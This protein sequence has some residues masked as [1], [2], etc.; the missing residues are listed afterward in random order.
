MRDVDAARRAPAAARAARRHAAASRP[1][2]R[3]STPTLAPTLVVTTDAAP[4]AAQSTPGRGGRQGAH[5][6]AAATGAGVDLAATLEVLAGLGVL[7]AMVEGGA[8]RH[9]ALVEAGLVDRLVAY[10]GARRV[11]GPDGRPA[12]DR[13][14]S[15]P[16]RR[17]APAGAWSTSP[18]S[19]PT[20]A[21]TTS[22]RRRAG[23]ERPDV[24]RHRRGARHRARASP[25]TRAARASRS[26][27][28]ACSTTPRSAR[29]S[30]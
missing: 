29:R 25:R 3:C 4:D 18:A 27:P 5:R 17:R 11:L 20:S 21:S 13:R 12:L 16:H 22:R 19:A 1:T 30:R 9:G 7:Q 8:A 6:A 2:A 15:R 14:R 23:G 10:V 28:R 24:H 26:P